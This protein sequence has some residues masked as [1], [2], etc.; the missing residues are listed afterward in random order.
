MK[1]EQV[2]HNKI[3]YVALEQVIGTLFEA[4]I[5]IL[6]W[7]IALVPLAVFGIIAKTIALQGF[8]PFKALECIYLNC[9]RGSI[10]ANLLLPE[11]GTLR[12]LGESATLFSWR[13]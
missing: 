3:D 8:A 6:S 9:A 1:A 10:F 12:L 7:V 13:L 11:S 4:V 2:A 5:R